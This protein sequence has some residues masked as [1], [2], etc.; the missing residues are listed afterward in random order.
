MAADRPTFLAGAGT[1][2]KMNAADM[3]C[4]QHMIN[5]EGVAVAFVDF[6]FLPIDPD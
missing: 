2:I 5:H 1:S 3:L 6:I 4:L